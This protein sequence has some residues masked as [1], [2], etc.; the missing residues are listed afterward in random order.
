MRLLLDECVPRKFRAG[1]VGHQCRT[2]PDE[3]LAGKKNGEL[4]ALA[5]KAGFQVFLTLDRG[6]EYE[7]NLQRRIIAIILIRAKSSRLADLLPHSTE[8]LRVL[9][10]IRPG[11][12]VKVG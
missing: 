4:L 1:L 2:V 6:L 9:G 7:Q 12:L 11:E 3:G 10:S 5:E 8:I